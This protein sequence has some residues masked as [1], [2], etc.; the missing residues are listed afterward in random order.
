LLTVLLFD[1]VDWKEKRRR[2][3]SAVGQTTIETDNAEAFFYDDFSSIPVCLR[4][5]QSGATIPLNFKCHAMSGS[6]LN[7]RV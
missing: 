7:L 2:R 3:R 5:F 4:A 6:K 1:I